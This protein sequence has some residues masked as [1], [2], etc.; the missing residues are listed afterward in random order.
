MVF[1]KRKGRR[2]WWHG[3]VE[4]SDR[5]SSGG[6]R[7]GNALAWRRGGNIAWAYIEG[8]IIKR[9]QCGRHLGH[10]REVRREAKSS[11]RRATTLPRLRAVPYSAKPLHPCL[12]DAFPYL[13]SCASWKY[14]CWLLRDQFALQL[15]NAAP[16]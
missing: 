10:G 12:P 11:A 9:R 13:P 8:K 16:L 6:G 15:H 14:R 5:P 1:Y 3:H 7:D 4:N 2:K